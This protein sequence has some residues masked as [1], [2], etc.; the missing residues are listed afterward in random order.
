MKTVYLS[1]LFIVLN[2]SIYAQCN[3]AIIFA[4]DS[5]NA[6]CFETTANTRNIFTNDIPDHTYGP[7]G[8][9]NNIQGQDLGFHKILQT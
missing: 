6:V 5:T 4:N 2:H 9:Q 8:G 7:F 3:S 1:L